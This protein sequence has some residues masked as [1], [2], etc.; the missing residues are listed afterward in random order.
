M[1]RTLD[2]RKKLFYT[3]CLALSPI[4]ATQVFSYYIDLCGY[5]TVVWLI[6]A[7]YGIYSRKAILDYLLMTAASFYWKYKI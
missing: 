5:F 4:F 6:V 3:L 1:G 7:L 2:F